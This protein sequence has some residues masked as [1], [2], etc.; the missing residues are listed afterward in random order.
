[1]KRQERNRIWGD[2]S[3]GDTLSGEGDPWNGCGEGLTAMAGLNARPGAASTVTEAAGGDMIDLISCGAGMGQGAVGQ[4]D[5]VPSFKVRPQRPTGRR[6]HGQAS[7]CPCAQVTS[8][9]GTAV[10]QDLIHSE[11]LQ[12]GPKLNL[13]IIGSLCSVCFKVWRYQSFYWY[14]SPFW[15]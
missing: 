1:M 10:P 8:P 9:L 15:I 7:C 11:K 14:N 4:V 2:E 12:Y 5:G 6:G 3:Q 13:M